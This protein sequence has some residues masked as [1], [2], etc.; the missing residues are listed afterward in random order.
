MATRP[1]CIYTSQK[2]TSVKCKTTS[3]ICNR[4]EY[5][6]RKRRRLRYR[7]IYIRFLRGWSQ[8]YGTLNFMEP[9]I[10]SSRSLHSSSLCTGPQVSLL[11]SPF[12][13]EKTP[14]PCIIILQRQQN[15]SWCD[16]KQEFEPSGLAI[17]LLWNQNIRINF[18]VLIYGLNLTHREIDRSIFYLHIIIACDE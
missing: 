16:V 15:K 18:F 17:F 6:S 11:G 9:L 10:F 1:Q 12:G 14:P 7:I 4:G 5:G 3:K 13:Y 8:K 2:S